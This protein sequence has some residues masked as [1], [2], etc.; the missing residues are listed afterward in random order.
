MEGVVRTEE[1]AVALS[2]LLASSFIIRGAQLTVVRRIEGQHVVSL[3]TSSISWIWKRITQYDSGNKKARNR[4][5]VFFKLLLPL[6]T[7]VNS[8]DSLAM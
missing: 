8:Q 3:H 6:L 4:S 1:H 7:A 5:I 2:K